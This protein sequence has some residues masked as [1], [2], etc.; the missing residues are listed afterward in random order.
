MATMPTL[1][2]AFTWVDAEGVQGPELAGSWA[3]LTIRAGGSIVTRVED[4]RA[5]TVRDFI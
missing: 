5:R 2:F 1:D 4:A 3:S